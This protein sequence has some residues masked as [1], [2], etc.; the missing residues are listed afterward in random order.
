MQRQQTQI[1]R[2]LIPLLK[3]KGLLVYST[4]SLEP[5]ENQQI[6]QRLLGRSSILRPGEETELKRETAG[7]FYVVIEGTGATEVGGKR[8]EWTRNDIF[9]APN[10]L[11]RR[12]INT[13][14]SDAVIYSVSDAALMRNIGQYYAQGRS[15]NG[16][17]T[18]L[19][20]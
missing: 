6:V 2:G 9:V 5:E 20:H 12:H 16:K 14:K 10:F 1:I 8:F 7:T 17:V 15:K 11:W 3:P 13:G 19:V 18:E 4:C